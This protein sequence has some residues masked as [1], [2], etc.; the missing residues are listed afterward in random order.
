MISMNGATILKELVAFMANAASLFPTKYDQTWGPPL[1]AFMVYLGRREGLHVRCGDL[2]NKV[3]AN[4]QT[5]GGA[6]LPQEYALLL[7]AWDSNGL[8]DTDACWVP[9]GFTIPKD[10]TSC[11]VPVRSEIVL[12]FEH[13]DESTMFRDGGTWTGTRMTAVLDEIRKIGN[14]RSDLKV[15]SYVSSQQEIASGHQI[16][17][18]RREIL[19]IRDPGLLTREWV[20]LEIGRYSRP[21]SRKELIMD[22]AVRCVV[23]RITSLDGGGNVLGTE[24]CRVPTP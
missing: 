22:G 18:I 6:E 8:L 7:S 16:E 24:Q 12:I 19:L 15:V 1:T 14:V 23:L 17:A 13:E 20:I 9:V 3:E 11:P 2:R 4:R 21:A 10:F 5:R